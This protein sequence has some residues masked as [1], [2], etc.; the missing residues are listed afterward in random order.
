MGDSEKINMEINI[1]DHEVQIRVPFDKQDSVRDLE[2]EVDQVFS[3]LRKIYPRKDTA[4]ILAMIVYRYASY[5]H[6]L[7]DLHAEVRRVAEDCSRA[8]DEIII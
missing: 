8:L 1:G 2:K 7:A 5:Y 4:E 6:D 3:G